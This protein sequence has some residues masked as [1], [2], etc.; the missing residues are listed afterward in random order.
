MLC[1][2]FLPPIN[3][4]LIPWKTINK[5]LFRVPPIFLHG[6]FYQID[7][8]FYR[9]NFTFKDYA[10]DQI[11]VRWAAVSLLSEK[12]SSWEVDETEVTN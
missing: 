6:F 8:N 5:K 7:C 1:E 9:H 2:H 3:I 12:V 11:S 4:V 10:I